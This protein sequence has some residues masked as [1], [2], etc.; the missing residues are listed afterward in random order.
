MAKIPPTEASEE[1]SDVCSRCG[2]LGYLVR[3][4]EN[5]ERFSRCCACSIIADVRRHIEKS[6]LSQLFD[7]YT[8][9]R[10]QVREPWQEVVKS[11]AEVFAAENKDRWFFVGGASGCGKTHLCTAICNGLLKR[12]MSL[13]YMQWRADAP[14]LKALINDAAAYRQ[15]MEPLKTARVLYIDDF[16]KGGV[17]GGDINLA[18]ELLNS[19][20]S[21]P[22]QITIISSEL[23]IE[24]LL[25]L[26]PAIG[27][28]IVERAGEYTFGLQ[29]KTN[30]RLLS[31]NS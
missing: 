17:T 21:T 28:R 20:Y 5:G 31:P 10:F 27:G 8:F 6:G 9:E 25:K 14:R 4:G 11:A 2:G 7:Q 30:W 26:D 1:T 16:F 15:A 29:G 24:Q 3:V 23:T 12:G 22:K 19:R 18:F 13:R